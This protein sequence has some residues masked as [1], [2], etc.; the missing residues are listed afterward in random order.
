M[1]GHLVQPCPEARPEMLSVDK[2]GPGLGIATQ[3][4]LVLE[5]QSPPG[6]VKGS[7]RVSGE[8]KMR[9]LTTLCMGVC[10]CMYVL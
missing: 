10:V 3:Q 2:K 8:N 7:E 4:K 9:F 5:M 1:L 6:H